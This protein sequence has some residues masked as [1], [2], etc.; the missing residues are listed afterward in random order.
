MFT[1]KSNLGD[2][3]P[4]AELKPSSAGGRDAV[5][6]HLDVSAVKPVSLH[7]SHIGI[8]APASGSPGTIGLT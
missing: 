5:P 8:R 1:I 4:K 7:R 3:W 2:D 6:P